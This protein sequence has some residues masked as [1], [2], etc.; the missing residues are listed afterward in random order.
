MIDRSTVLQRAPQLKLHLSS[1]NEVVVHRD[2]NKCAVPFH[3]LRILDFFSRPNTFDDAVEQLGSQTLG[4]QDWINLTSSI[5]LLVEAGVLLPAGDSAGPVKATETEGFGAAWIHIR[6][7]ND[8]Q[9]TARYLEAIRRIVRPGDVVVDVGTGTG[10]LAVAAARAGARHVYAI[11]ATGI[12]RFAEKV[13]EVN[14][15]GSRITLVPG[16]STQVELPESADVI[17]SEI[18]GNNPFGERV[19][20]AIID[21]R[22]R[23]GKPAPRMVPGRMTVF[24]RAVMVPDS[25]V[26]EHMFT[27][28]VT[29]KWKRTYGIDF[30]PLAEARTERPVGFGVKLGDI[31]EWVTLAADAPIVEIDF[32][33]INTTSLYER[34][35]C[36]AE[37]DGILN[38]IVICFILELAEGV[39]LSITPESAGPNNHWYAM[40]WLL[41]QPLQLKQSQRFELRFSYNTTGIH[42]GATAR[43]LD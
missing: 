29:S 3:G 33:Q 8:D 12:G 23:F 30:S 15:E 13:F 32:A 10:V 11:E 14:D 26:Q 43:L 31:K 41:P 35:A 1:N 25:L 38:G 6:M 20:E 7:L 37:T 19:L 21:A 22:K 34:V 24:A 42:D 9:R 39:T 36:V 17:V 16:W 40:T 5:L 27:A 18:I 4:T 28:P 2:N